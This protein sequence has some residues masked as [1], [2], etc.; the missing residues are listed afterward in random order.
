MFSALTVIVQEESVEEEEAGEDGDEDVAG[1]SDGLVD[2]L[3]EVGHERGAIVEHGV[4]DEAQQRLQ[5]EV[6]QVLHSAP[7]PLTPDPRAGPVT[8]FN[9][10]TWGL[11][12][13]FC[14]FYIAMDVACSTSSIFN[15][16][17]ISIDSPLSEILG[18]TYILSAGVTIYPRVDPAWTTV[19]HFRGRH[20][21]ALFRARNAH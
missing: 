5:Q 1:A 12:P 4:V 7:G 9:G 14:D 13:L 19:M 3:F 16:V 21:T 6:E 10:N 8:P 11:P 2:Q 20:F 15:L 17:A 18:S